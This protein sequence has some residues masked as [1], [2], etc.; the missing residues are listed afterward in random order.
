LKTIPGWVVGGRMWWGIA[1]VVA[2]VACS[3]TPEAPATPETTALAQPTAVVTSSSA[4]TVQIRVALASTDL[5][6]GS[7]RLVFGVLGDSGPLR[8]PDVK[9]RFVYVDGDA[10]AVLF[11]A[12]ARFVRWPGG[13]SGVYVIDGVEFDSAGR[14]GMIVEGVMDDGTALIGQSGLVVNQESSSPAVGS[15][16][17]R[18]DSKTSSDVTDLSELTTSPT[19]DPGLYELSI[20]D[21]I[22]GGQTTVVTFATPA[23]CQTATCGPQVEVLSSLRLGHAESAFIHVEVYDNPDEIEGDLSRAIISPLMEE[24]GLLTEP[25]TFIIDVAGQIAAKFEG[26]VTEDELEAALLSLPG[27]GGANDG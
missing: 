25:F 26:F 14:W 4:S 13:A 20:A 23:F 27:T 10:T 21:A 11:E 5:A 1:L 19:P 16:A 3:S 18:S 17:P 2:A 15:P 24:W 6:V 12:D 8:A 22:G 7:N 9:A